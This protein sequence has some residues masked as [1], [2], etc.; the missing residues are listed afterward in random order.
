MLLRSIATL[1]CCLSVCY[2]AAAQVQHVIRV[3]S[4]GD[5]LPPGTSARLGTTRMRYVG[6]SDYHRPTIAADGKKAF[7]GSC[8]WDLATGKPLQRITQKL[9][10]LS[11]D[12]SVGMSY[13]N[14]AWV[15]RDTISGTKLGDV[16]ADDVDRSIRFHGNNELVWVTESGKIKRWD[17]AQQK[18]VRSVDCLAGFV[19]TQEIVANVDCVMSAAISDDLRTVVADLGQPFV[20]EHGTG[21]MSAFVVVAWDTATGM[22]LWRKVN[23]DVPLDFSFTPGGQWLAYHTPKGDAQICDTRTGEVHASMPYE[24]LN[25]RGTLGDWAVGADG[26]TI[27]VPS[28]TCDVAIWDCMTQK[29][30]QEISLMPGKIR[31]GCVIYPMLLQFASDGRSLF[32]VTDHHLQVVELATGKQRLLWDGHRDPVNF[33]AFT[34]EGSLISGCHKE[35]SRF[36]TDEVLTWNIASGKVIDRSHAWVLVD[37]YGI[38]TVSA[39][40]TI[41][42]RVEPD[43]IFTIDLV[44]GTK[45]SKIAAAPKENQYTEVGFS[46]RGAYAGLAQQSDRWPILDSRTGKSF[47]SKAAPYPDSEGL[48][49]SANETL[50]AWRDQSGNMHIVECATGKEVTHFGQ[51]HDTDDPDRSFRAILSFSPKADFLAVFDRRR[52]AV[53]VWHVSKR[54]LVRTLAGEAPNAI[55]CACLAWSPDGRMIAGS[56]KNTIRIWEVASGKLRREFTG[57]EAPI[58]CLAFSPDNRLLASGS[59]DTTVL[60]WDLARVER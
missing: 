32:A 48:A 3:D 23:K 27:A 50:M 39:D 59:A 53:Q 21:S 11:G 26:K 13:S 24:K 22:E 36:C 35:D 12:L 51:G 1:V 31:T 45:L 17:I 20:T 58:R 15:V 40:H 49:F 14:K 46:P 9:G 28:S 2:T 29:K 55:H 30:I 7:F 54:K 5:E 52:G 60:L 10:M 16:N 57:H 8:L 25:V 34:A 37:K 6:S 33:L 44:N 56:D 42:A 47:L 41:G 43:G 4:L 19:K 38:Q 18:V